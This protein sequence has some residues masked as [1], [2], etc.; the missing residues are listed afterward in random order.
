MKSHL[1]KLLLALIFIG[2]CNK[3]EN[4]DTPINVN[5]ISINVMGQIVNESGQPL[6]NVQ[7][8][9]GN[10][11][12]TTNN[13]GIYSLTGVSVSKTRAV[14]RTTLAGYWDC[15]KGFVPSTTGLNY[16]SLTMPAKSATNNISGVSGGTVN[17]NGA[18]II[19][20]ANAFV[21]LA[22]AAFVGN[23]KVSVKHLPTTDVNFGSL[24]PG[25]DLLALNAAGQERVLISYGMVGVELFDN[26]G[27]EIQLA[28]GKKATIQL[29]IASTQLSSAT[30]T[31]PLWY[32][33]VTTQLWKEE[34]VATRQG[35]NYVGEVSHFTWWNC[36]QP[37][38]GVQIKGK[39][40]DCNGNPFPNASIYSNTGVFYTYTNINGEYSGWVV[41]GS[42]HAIYSSSLGYQN[43]Q[44]ETSPP[45]VAGQVFTYPDLVIPC[46]PTGQLN[47][48][49]VNC[50]SLPVTNTLILSNSISQ[51]F[52]NSNSGAIIMN[53]PCGWYDIESHI[54][55]VSYYDSIYVDCANPNYRTIQL[56]N[57]SSSNTIN[58]GFTIQFANSL[59]NLTD[60]LTIPT[61]VNSN[62]PLIHVNDLTSL[63]QNPGVGVYMSGVPYTPGVYSD[64]SAY[65]IDIY[66]RT[67]NV[68]YVAQPNPSLGSLFYVEMIQTGLP[69]D[70][71]EFNMTGNV[72]IQNL[73]TGLFY[74]D[75][76]SSFHGKFIRP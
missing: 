54:F 55:G 66:F 25:G 17:S 45:L 49:I 30:A 6:S 71:V 76:I 2:S 12:S 68:L 8:S 13:H 50:D 33:D 43:S 70:T 64:T 38:I 26:S 28:P 9:L 72:T 36:D 73:N 52:Y 39:V 57:P 62:P 40:V 58:Y 51:Y 15:S 23:V 20:P 42:A 46:L 59:I 34:G 1:I 22:G 74:N 48:T 65:Y 3:D 32:F 5:T 7:V 29:P 67:N 56:C 60:S 10:K 19:F 53:L 37:G 61:T 11:T 69:N 63:T 35:N 44:T 21:N 27:N 47:L 18:S 16:C 24:I 75:S 41:Q 31:I 14:L 4:N